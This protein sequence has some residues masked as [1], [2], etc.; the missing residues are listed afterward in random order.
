MLMRRIKVWLKH[1]IK[2]AEFIFIV[3]KG[4]Q[5]LVNNT[6]SIIKKYFGDFNTIK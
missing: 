3:I 5:R 6:F 2:R 4:F 1:L